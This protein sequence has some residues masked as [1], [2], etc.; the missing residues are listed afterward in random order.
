M[1]DLRV[2][3]F[4]ASR[5]TCLE[6]LRGQY[7]YTTACGSSVLSAARFVRSVWR[8]RSGCRR[9]ISNRGRNDRRPN[10]RHSAEIWR[11]FCASVRD[12]QRG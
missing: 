3:K 12:A 4:G 9:W 10:V 1:N 5:V 8:L 11:E 7:V 2:M 6:A